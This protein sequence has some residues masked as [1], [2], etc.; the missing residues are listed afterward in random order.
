MPWLSLVP[1]VAQFAL[2]RGRMYG[3]ASLRF[4][5]F[6]LC[7]RHGQYIPPRGRMYGLA[8]LGSPTFLSGRPGTMYT[9]NA[10]SYIR[11]NLAFLR[12]PP[13]LRGG[14][15]TMYTAKVRWKEK[16]ALSSVL[17]DS[18]SRVGGFTIKQSQFPKHLVSFR[19]NSCLPHYLAMDSKH[20]IEGFK[21][22]HVRIDGHNIPVRPMRFEEVS[23]WNFGIRP[24]YLNHFVRIYRLMSKNEEILLTFSEP[25]KLWRKSKSVHSF[26]LGLLLC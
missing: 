26:C 17:F 15:G 4:P 5:P 20:I 7:G 1:G 22:F 10:S 2:S 6:F 16:K 9:T 23:F 25:A 8:S 14:R 11:C 19:C 18:R 21:D 3:L 13:L 12:F 24:T